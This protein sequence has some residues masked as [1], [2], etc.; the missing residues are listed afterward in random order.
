M[1]SFTKNRWTG[2][3]KT[4]ANGYGEFRLVLEHSMQK[5]TFK[6]KQDA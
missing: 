2:G 5:K 1:M 4:C 3:E 6:S